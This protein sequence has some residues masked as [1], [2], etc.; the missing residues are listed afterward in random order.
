ML[1]SRNFLNILRVRLE[2]LAEADMKMVVFW[3][4]A[5]CNLVEIY[6]RSRSAWCLQHQGDAPSKRL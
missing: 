6:R 2:V 5:S 4:V 1:I 3:V